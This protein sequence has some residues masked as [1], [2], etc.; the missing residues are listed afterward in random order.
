MQAG[1]KIVLE[2]FLTIHYYLRG[3]DRAVVYMLTRESDLCLY[4]ECLAHATETS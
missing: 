4:K 3:L 2:S 1:L